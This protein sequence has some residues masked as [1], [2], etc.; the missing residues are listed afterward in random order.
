MC[1]ES[2]V[3]IGFK[4]THGH[5]T[6]KSC[7]DVGIDE[8]HH[9]FCDGMQVFTPEKKAPT[10]LLIEELQEETERLKRDLRL[11]RSR[12]DRVERIPYEPAPTYTQPYQP[13]YWT[14]SSSDSTSA[15]STMGYTLTTSGAADNTASWSYRG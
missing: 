12:V 13:V 3:E 7:I 1:Q 15:T 10:T 9:H 6:C 4:C 2:D 11:E 8:C 5:V 14:G